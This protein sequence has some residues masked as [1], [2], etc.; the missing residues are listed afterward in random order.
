MAKRKYTAAQRKAY[1]SGMGYAA[2]QAGKRI[3]F[4]SEQNKAS[5][6]A[7]LAKGKER[8]AKLPKKSGGVK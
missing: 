1:Y 4:K 3:D 6:K 7:G 5:F 8:A 2:C